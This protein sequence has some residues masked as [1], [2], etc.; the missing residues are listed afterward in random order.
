M[1][2]D[3]STTVGRKKATKKKVVKKTSKKTSTKKAAIGKKASKPAKA[4]LKAAKSTKSVEKNTSTGVKNNSKGQV[5]T[6]KKA[7][8]KK[9]AVRKSRSNGHDY[10]ISADRREELIEK[11]AFL[12]STRRYSGFDDQQRD[13]LQAEVVI[14][15]IF[16]VDG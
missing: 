2:Q 5:S 11:A 14:D 4:T 3:A 10:V 13:W 6:K 9:A 7:V 16:T 8:K 12:I 15:M 1:A